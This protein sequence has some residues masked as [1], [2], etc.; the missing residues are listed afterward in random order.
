MKLENV[1]IKYSKI[2]LD[3]ININVKRGKVTLLQGVSGSGKSSLLYRI[4]LISDQKNYSYTI[5]NTQ[6]MDLNEEEQSFIRKKYMSFVLQD[7]ILFE[8]YDIL[9]NLQLYSSFNSMKYTDKDY[10]NILD[11]VKL[12][13]S[14][15]ESIQTLSGGEK[16]RVAI[17]C[18]LCK[19]TQILI[20]DEPTSSLDQ[21]NEKQIFS[22]LKD[23]AHLDNKYVII[24]SHSEYASEYADEIFKIN[25]CKIEKIKDCQNNP[26][27]VS[28]NVVK[29]KMNNNFYFKYIQYFIKKYKKMFT[30]LIG[31][32]M[33]SLFLLNF[34]LYYTNYQMNKSKDNFYQ[35]SENQM[36]LTKEKEKLY[37]NERLPYFYLK[38]K[39]IPQKNKKIIPFIETYANVEGVTYPVVPYFPENKLENRQLLSFNNKGI[40]ISYPLYREFIE[41]GIDIQSLN[42]E[43][44]VRG[45]EKDFS[46]KSKIYQTQGVLKDKVDCP[47]LNKQQNNYI[48]MDY[49]Y[50]KP[51]YDSLGFDNHM[52]YVGY[53]LF[54]QNFDDYV[55]LY[56]ELLNKDLGVNNFFKGLD[57]MNKIISNV[58]IFKIIITVSISLITLVT[59]T[60]VYSSYFYKR[61]KEFALLKINGL[62]HRNL[63]TLTIY[64]ISFQLIVAGTM[65]I[66]M[67]L[68]Y[69]RTC[70]IFF[71]ILIDL[72]LL[73]GVFG[74]TIFYNYIFLK[75][76]IPEKVL[77]N[78][79]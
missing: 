17:A 49:D 61:Q 37:V 71:F 67:L 2:V 46:L 60:V 22:I 78:G 19:N 27:D 48:Y 65:S 21:E 24:S 29:S 76:I 28:I 73:V 16:Q 36:F 3:N 30:L 12:H 9:G 72:L 47:Y 41:K 70:Q 50:L 6:L 77:R 35:L 59:F 44:I 74:L 7:Y 18:A 56:N 62:S 51:I 33:I 52:M 66:V 45:K 14:L 15:H 38:Q 40:Y 43:L 5:S 75:K 57:E 34:S 10:K 58:E 55:H 4:G 8:Q 26:T 20:L 13:I 32:I 42:I 11:K 79:I 69:M 64:E 53:T 25:N 68:C 39:Y 23:I 54:T 1:N 63:L 31:I